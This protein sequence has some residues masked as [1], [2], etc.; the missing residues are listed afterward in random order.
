MNFRSIQG[1]PADFL[2]L[3]TLLQ[4]YILSAF[5]ALGDLPDQLTESKFQRCPKGSV[6]DG[7]RLTTMDGRSPLACLSRCAELAACASVNVCPKGESGRVTCSLMTT[8]RHE[9][10]DHL[11]AAASPSCFFAKK[12]GAWIDAFIDLFVV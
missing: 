11:T 1:N 12:V 4:S 8:G 9:S 2:L 3:T 5:S 6:H 7:Q 10:C